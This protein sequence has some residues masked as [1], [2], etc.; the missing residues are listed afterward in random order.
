MNNEF[1][2]KTVE[3]LVQ[4]VHEMLNIQN[5]HGNFRIGEL[6]NALGQVQASKALLFENIECSGRG[7]DELMPAYPDL[8]YDI[9]I[10]PH[11][12]GVG[13]AH[14]WRGVYS[15]L[16]LEPSAEIRTV[17]DTLTELQNIIGKTLEGYKGGDFLMSEGTLVW[18][19]FYGQ[20]SV[21][22]RT[23]VYKDSE[24]TEPL[25]VNL[26][27]KGIIERE[28]EVVILYQEEQDS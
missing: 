11:R 28:N 22:S 12:S 20:C 4:H 17:S 21:W 7:Y 18:C 19:S 27:I 3:D 16:A 26:A 8:F 25:S 10:D 13:Y 24:T 15:Q 23:Q 1:Q 14:S 5:E 6:I 2:V 9:D